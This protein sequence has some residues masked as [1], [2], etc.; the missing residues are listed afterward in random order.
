MGRNGVGCGWGVVG[1]DA[2]GIRD[3]VGCGWH[4]G[5]GGMWMR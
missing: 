1:Q 3:G 4:A 5:W 2:G